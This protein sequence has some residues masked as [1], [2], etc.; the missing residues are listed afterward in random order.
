MGF[1]V[2]LKT[3][4][5]SA[6]FSREWIADYLLNGASSFCWY[7]GRGCC[8]HATKVYL[9][10][11]FCLIVVWDL[12]HC[13]GVICKLVEGARTEVPSPCSG[14]STVSLCI[15]S[16]LHVLARHTVK[17]QWSNC[18]HC[19]KSQALTIS[20]MNVHSFFAVL[21]LTKTRNITIFSGSN[22]SHLLRNQS[23]TNKCWHTL[24]QFISIWP[25]TW[26]IKWL[27]FLAFWDGFLLNT[28]PMDFF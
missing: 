8:H 23:G 28:V 4:W 2:Q 6:T 26:N 10:P 5:M 12:I 11:V 25:S 21:N 15:T 9:H 14:H 19:G 3:S 24:K 22:N 17:K 16:H 1:T 13:P 27:C 18:D 20:N 7:W